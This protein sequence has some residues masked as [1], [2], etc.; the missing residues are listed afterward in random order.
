[1]PR[2]PTPQP[3]DVE[4]SILRALWKRGPSPVGAIHNLLKEEKPKTNYSTTLRMVQVM[5]DK[6]ILVRDETLRPHIYQPAMSQEETQRRMLD[7]LVRKAFGGEVS[8]VVVSAL[9]TKRVSP[10][11]LAEIK[12]LIRDLERGKR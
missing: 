9:S 8:R 11:Q 4:L 1:M 12:K 3:T 2:K 6:G 5:F 10:Q 7:D